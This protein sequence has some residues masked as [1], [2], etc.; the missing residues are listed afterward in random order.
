MKKI[1][2]GNVTQVN[3]IKSNRGK[4]KISFGKFLLHAFDMAEIVNVS[5]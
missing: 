3:F 2:C 4:K 5:K 1:L